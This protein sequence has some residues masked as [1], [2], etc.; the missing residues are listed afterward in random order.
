MSP[1][2]TENGQATPITP[3]AARAALDRER[4]QRCMACQN[5]INQVLQRHRCKLDVAVLLRES[6]VIPQ[7]GIVALD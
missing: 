5:E 4:Q 2:Q 1:T 7:L 3:D 6:A